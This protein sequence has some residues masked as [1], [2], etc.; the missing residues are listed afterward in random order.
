MRFGKPRPNRIG[1]Y[2]GRLA[3]SWNRIVQGAILSRRRKI[4]L[5]SWV[6]YRARSNEL[7]DSILDFIKARSLRIHREV[8]RRAAAAE[9]AARDAP[10]RSCKSRKKQRCGGSVW[11]SNPPF[12]SRR[13]ESPALKAGRVTG[14]FAPPLEIIA[15]TAQAARRFATGAQ[16]RPS[17]IGRHGG[18]RL[19]NSGS[20]SCGG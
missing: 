9:V 11:E 19:R 6:Y 14:P 13:A 20:E 10:W 5:R 7:H 12:D 17:I 16:A 18:T 8:Q 15:E 4:K 2:F 3:T 1:I